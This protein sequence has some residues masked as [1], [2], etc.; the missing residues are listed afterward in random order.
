MNLVYPLTPGTAMRHHIESAHSTWHATFSNIPNNV[1][2]F[3]DGCMFQCTPEEFVAHHYQAV[4]TPH[5]VWKECE[6]LHE[7]RWRRNPSDD[8]YIDL[9]EEIVLQPHVN[10]YVEEDI[11][12]QPHVI[13]YVEEENSEVS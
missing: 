13:E 4:Q 12:L 2:Y 8:N 1:T 6:V 10:E 9:T 5:N 3:H 7:G 11:V